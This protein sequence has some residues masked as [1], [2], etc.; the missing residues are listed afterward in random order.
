[1]K[2]STDRILTTHTGSLVRP[3]ELIDVMMAQQQDQPFDEGAFATALPIAVAEVVRKQAEAGVDIVSDGEYGKLGFWSYARTRLRGLESGPLRPGEI[4][5][6]GGQ[7]RKTFQEFY[8]QYDKFQNTIWMPPS[9]QASQEPANLVRTV[10]NGPVSYQGKAA[11]QRDA[12]NFRAA[13]A[14]VN[15]EEAFIPAVS[16][17]MVEYAAKNEYFPSDEE[18]VY[19]LADALKEEYNAIVDAGFLLQIDAP[20]LPATYDRILGGDGDLR[21]YHRYAATRVE[22]INHAL[23]GIPEEKVRYHI[24]WGSWN[25]P[26][27]TDVPLK[28]VLDLL[29]TVR[30]QA[31]SIEAANPRHEHEFQIWEDVKLP[32]GKVLIPGVIA[33]T[34]NVVEHPEL[35]AM[36][37]KNFARLVGRENVIGGTDCGFSQSWN[38]IRVH[39][40]VQWAKLG[41]L[42]EGARLATEELWGKKVAH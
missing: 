29:L 8:A 5:I 35:V 10:C 14:S 25:A 21:D 32:D 7:D 9:S 23:E 22:A 13:L 17:S 2:R 6:A 19:A 30:A 31:Y 26:H 38:S 37:I 24:C 36:R 12:D 3:P 39:P 20:E 42:A 40:S 41:A 34:T 18:Y 11:F 27:T 16:P 4:A 1:M 15:V 33:H 28:D